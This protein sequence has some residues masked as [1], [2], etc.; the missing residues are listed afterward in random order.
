MSSDVATL[1]RRLPGAR[2]VGVPVV[3]RTVKRRR[4]LIGVPR[5]GTWKGA[6]RRFQNSLARDQQV[7]CWLRYSY[8]YFQISVKTGLDRSYLRL[9]QNSYMLSSMLNKSVYPSE[10][11]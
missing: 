1:V 9:V 2:L 7:R 4:R 5:P 3:V 6:C 11:C 8:M 10:K